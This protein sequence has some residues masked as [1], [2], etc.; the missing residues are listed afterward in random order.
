[1]RILLLAYLGGVL[2]ILSPCILPMIPLV[3]ARTGRSFA[4][5]IAPMLVGLALAFTAAALIATATAH[6]LVV[7]NVVGRDIALVL[8]AIIGVTLLS[9][10]AAELVARPVTRAG[11]A[12]MSAAHASGPARLASLWLNTSA[13]WWRA[14]W[15]ALKRRS[16]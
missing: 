4:R 1:M 5:E 8:F 10:R 14:I 13:A 11:A 12:M 3:F 2:T 7:A 9:S 6:W 15:L 16:M